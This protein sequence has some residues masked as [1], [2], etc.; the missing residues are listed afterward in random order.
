[1][2]KLLA[3]LLC[4]L[5]PICAFAGDTGY[6]IVYDGGSIP[7]VKVGSGMRLYIEGTNVRIMDGKDRDR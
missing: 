7:S 1:M 3:V 6:K 2:K 4:V 5:F